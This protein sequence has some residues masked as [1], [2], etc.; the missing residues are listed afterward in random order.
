LNLGWIAIPN[1]VWYLS[2]PVIFTGMLAYLWSY[3]AAVA[4]V[5]L[6]A[7]MSSRWLWW[8]YVK[9]VPTSTA[10]AAG[11]RPTDERPDAK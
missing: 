1:L 11:A 8:H 7:G 2:I 10:P 6:V 5:F 3:T 9:S 4:I